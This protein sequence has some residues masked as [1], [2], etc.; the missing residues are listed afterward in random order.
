MKRFLLTAGLLALALPAFAAD[1]IIEPVP[2][3]ESAAVGDWTGFYAGLQLGGAFG[4]DDGQLSIS[5]FTPILQT[6]FAP[7][8]DGEFDTGV[9]GGAHVGY[10][11]QAGNIVFGV[12]ADISATDIGDRQS[13]FS[14]T[15]A[16]YTIEREL[17]FFATARG[18]LGYAV[19]PRFLGYV[20]GGVAFGDV[21]FN[22]S[23]PGS[24]AVVQSITGDQDSVG[25]T[26][27][28]GGEVL[29]TENVSLGLEYLYTNLG[30][31]DYTVNIAG[32]GPNRNTFGAIG[33]PGT[34]LTGSDDDFDFHTVQMKL[35]YRF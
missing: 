16:A 23:Q 33:G 9:T 28:A 1:A 6:R 31:N 7:G 20:T 21:D 35:S 27:G 2:V 22:Y 29:L 10:D 4:G 14:D 13:G 8:F 11:W 18:K 15:P 32:A 25:Y 24:S 5:P 30:D 19:S 17:N 3:V 26:V 12:L 34:D